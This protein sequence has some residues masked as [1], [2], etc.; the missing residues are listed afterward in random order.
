LPAIATVDA[1]RLIAAE[2]QAEIA[3]DFLYIG[4]ADGLES[5]L[6][7]EAGMR[8]VSIR[9]GKLRRSAN[10]LR[11]LS[12]ANLKDACRVPLGF[13]QALKIVGV[14]RPD[15]T[16]STGG[17]VSVPAVMA[18]ALLKRPV[19]VH[20]QTVQVG[21][22]NRWS[23]H[24]ATRIALSYP[25]S[26][27]E[28]NRADRRKSFVTGGVVRPLVLSGNA[29]RARK[30]MGFDGE[31]AELPVIYVTGGAQGSTV[32][33][34]AILQSL[35]ALTKKCCIIHQCGRQKGHVDQD[36]DRL[37][38]ASDD[39]PSNLRGRYR[40]SSFI[41]DEIGDVYAVASL[42]VGRSGAG[43]IS[44]VCAT[45]KASILIPLVPT[46]GDEQT[47]N[48][49]RLANAG[50]AVVIE[51]RELTGEVLLQRI[52]DLL[53]NPALVEEMGKSALTLA[54]PDAAA[55]LAQAVLQLGLDGTRN[56]KIA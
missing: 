35:P 11:M 12:I 48:A 28:L 52:S 41:G 17:Y 23:A 53:E 6:A 20:E 7:I 30:I 18:S 45:G 38:A 32:I 3:L 21:L 4:S 54:T 51:Q 25:E 33:N 16:F 1:I 56:S 29:C 31:L 2:E 27:S 34:N 24:V 43:T 46:G 49:R 19:L 39:L 55:K 36:E 14:F 40:L 47:K 15:V 50:A 8:F 42:I 13:M 22:A 5:R 26:A 10:P 9:T 44:E 37:R